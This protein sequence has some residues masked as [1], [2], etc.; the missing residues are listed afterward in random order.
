MAFN[1]QTKSVSEDWVYYAKHHCVILIWN[2]YQN[3]VQQ[4]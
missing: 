2:N 4:K 3:N 1:F